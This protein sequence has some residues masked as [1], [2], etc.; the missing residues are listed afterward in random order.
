L[1]IGR[2]SLPA[3]SSLARLL[4]KRRGVRNPATPPPLTVQRILRWARTHFRG[5]GSWP[6]VKS[7]PI[8]EAPGETWQIVNYSLQ[9]GRR[10]LSKGSTLAKLLV[11]ELGIRIRGLPPPLS[12]RQILAWADAH[13]DRTGKWP[14]K[15]SGPI[16]EAPGEN[17]NS[18]CYALAAGIR[19]L[20]SGW[21]L[22][23]LLTRKRGVRARG[24]LPFR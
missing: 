14:T 15:R 2:R 4:A 19:G 10:G 18:V 11:G 16:P 5:T 9:Q 8:P 17:W 1:R 20:P 3:G 23:S 22:R 21:S 7:G 13:H 12:L 6:S 24:N